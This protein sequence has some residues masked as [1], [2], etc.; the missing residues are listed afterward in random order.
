MNVAVRI[1]PGSEGVQAITMYP[2]ERRPT[3]NV[4]GAGSAMG[5]FLAKKRQCASKHV[6]ESL[7]AW[8]TFA[9]TTHYECAVSLR[10]SVRLVVQ[11]AESLAKSRHLGAQIAVLL[12]EV[13]ETVQV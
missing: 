3:V 6:V 1:G 4:A 8:V 11:L 7:D 9:G 2:S 13:S 10:D 5:L 12:V